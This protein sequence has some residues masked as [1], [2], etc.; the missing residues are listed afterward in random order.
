MASNLS[1]VVCVY[2]I[3]QVSPQ[4]RLGGALEFHN[5]KICY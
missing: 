2:F 4:I 1:R 3:T 5:L